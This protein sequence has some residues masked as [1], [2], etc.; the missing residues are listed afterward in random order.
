MFMCVC[1]ITVVI[2][3]YIYKRV[4]HLHVYVHNYVEHMNRYI[5]IYTYI[6]VNCKGYNMYMN[7][8]FFIIMFLGAAYEDGSLSNCFKNVCPKSRNHRIMGKRLQRDHALCFMGTTNAYQ[9]VYFQM[10]RPFDKPSWTSI[11]WKVPLA[12]HNWILLS[13]DVS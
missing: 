4:Q 6:Y 2:Y 12:Q 5:Y 8:I 9:C 1:N 10:R 7:M 11:S 3:I 13:V